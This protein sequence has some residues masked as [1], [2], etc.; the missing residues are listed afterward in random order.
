MNPKMFVATLVLV[1]VTA[2]LLVTTQ[3]QQ[4]RKG[5]S[6]Q[7]ASTH[8]ASPMP[9]ADR[10]D[11][12]IVTVTAEGNLFFGADPMTPDELGEW[13]KTHPRNREAKLYIKA[14]AGASFSAVDR[15]LRIADEMDFHAP[16]LLTAQPEQ[17]PPGAMV[18]PK[19]L[20]VLVGAPTRAEIVVQVNSNREPVLE[21]NGEQTS[22]AALQSVLRGLLQNQSEKGVLI[23]AGGKVTFAQVASVVD[24]CRSLGAMPTLTTPEL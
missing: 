7:M 16:V 19:G 2:A 21:V 24:T 1:L 13:M 14:D 9:E 5:V 15:V 20:E 12:W 23:K 18:P 11:A 6:V 8:N 10:E 4:L 3:A 17:T 22:W